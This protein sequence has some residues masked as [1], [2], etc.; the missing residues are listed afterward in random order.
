MGDYLINICFAHQALS[1]MNTETMS[2]F[3]V[4]SPVPSTMPGIQY[5]PNN[6]E[7]EEMNNLKNIIFIF[8]FNKGILHL[9]IYNQ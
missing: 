5:M 9:Q 1:N 8:I 7:V 2:V 6:C 3:T 4:L